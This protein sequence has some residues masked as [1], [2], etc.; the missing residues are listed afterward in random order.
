MNHAEQAVAALSS[1]GLDSAVMLM[2]LSREWGRVHPIYV[3]CG[4]W[5]EEE[6]LASLHRFLAA[7]NARPIQEVQELCLPMTD[8][9]AD[10]WYL[11]G[12]GIPGY[13]EADEQWEITGRNLILLSKTA[14]WCKIHDVHAIALGLLAG[15]PFPDA[16]PDF[17]SASENA[18]RLGLGG[19]ELTLLRPLSELRKSDVV[20]LGKNLP[21]EL[22]LS[23]ASPVR[24]THC[25]LCGKCRER[26]DAFKA[27][28]VADRTCYRQAVI[29]KETSL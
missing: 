26:I 12:S 13:H 8:L 7:V 23:C 17:F 29:D 28:R 19:L 10:N 21:L 24:G 4:L 6:E 11:T 22:T 14:V 3:R 18:F 27:A 25:G 15:N 2:E 1:G 20:R 9:Y 16:T 5:W